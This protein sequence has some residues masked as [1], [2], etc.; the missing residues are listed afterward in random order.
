[1]MPS[2]LLEVTI[3]RAAVRLSATVSSACRHSSGSTATTRPARCAASTVSAN[4]TVFGSCTAITELAGRPDSM[5]CAASAE[6]CAVGLRI[7]QALRRL[8]GDALLVGGIDQRQR[9][10]LPRQDRA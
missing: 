10:R 3:A 6:I 1:M 2:I 4:S 7:G 5:K 9:V 8:A